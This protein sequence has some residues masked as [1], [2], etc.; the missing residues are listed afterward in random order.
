MSPHAAAL[1]RR[2]V[3]WTKNDGLRLIWGV[4]DVPESS[5]IQ[6]QTQNYCKFCQVLFHKVE[7]EALQ[8]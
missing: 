5:T 3:W 2:C 4:S 8:C 7:G 1:E 6:S